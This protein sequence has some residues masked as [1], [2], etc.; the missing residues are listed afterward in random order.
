MANLT[1]GPLVHSSGTGCS[2]CQLLEISVDG[3]GNVVTRFIGYVALA[4]NGDCLL[5]GELGDCIAVADGFGEPE[6]SFKP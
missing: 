3:D 4:P 2:V 5:T 1:L 6:A